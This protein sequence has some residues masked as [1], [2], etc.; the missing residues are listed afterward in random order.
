M[1]LFGDLV[2]TASIRLCKARLRSSSCPLIRIEKECRLHH[3]LVGF[4]HK[5]HL[6]LQHTRITRR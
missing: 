3:R 4:P 6:T 2:F 5:H 1:L